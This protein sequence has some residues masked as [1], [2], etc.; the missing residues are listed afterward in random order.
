MANR[1]TKGCSKLLTIREMHIKPTVTYNFT[2]VRMAIIKKNTS[3]KYWLGCGEKGTLTTLLVG[4]FVQPL[5]KTMQVSQE[6]KNRTT[7]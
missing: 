6:T 2:L 3:N 1:H 5:W 7:I 4:K